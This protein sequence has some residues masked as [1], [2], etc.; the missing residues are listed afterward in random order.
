[1]FVAVHWWSPYTFTKVQDVQIVQ[2]VPAVSEEIKELGLFGRL[3]AY[4]LVLRIPLRF[5]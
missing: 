5:R 3:S 1:M 4:I 2:A